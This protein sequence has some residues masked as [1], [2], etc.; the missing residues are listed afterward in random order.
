MFD[1]VLVIV[2]VWRVICGYLSFKL[3]GV[4]GVVCIV[5][6]IFVKGLGKW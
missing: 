3:W 1:V 2:E 6:D 4:I 5:L